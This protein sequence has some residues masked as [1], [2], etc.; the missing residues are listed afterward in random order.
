MEVDVGW[1]KYTTA[2]KG[3]LYVCSSTK[4]TISRLQ[5]QEYIR[6][7]HLE[8]TKQN[9]RNKVLTSGEWKYYQMNRNL[10]SA[11]RIVKR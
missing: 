5:G 7:N 10:T 4:A 3:L 2:R 11:V 9:R 8:W 1:E 6:S